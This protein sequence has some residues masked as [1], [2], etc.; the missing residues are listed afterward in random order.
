LL[1]AG[2]G[3]AWCAGEGDGLK[4]LEPKVFLPDGREFKT[5]KPTLTFSRT[6]YVDGSAANAS[7]DNPGTKVRPFKTINKAAQVAGAGQ[8]VLVAAGVYR[9]WVRPKRG[10]ESPAKMISYQAAPGA[11]VVIKGSRVVTDKWLAS[12]AKGVWKLTLQAKWFKNG[13]NPFALPNVTPKQFD[14]MSW[15]QRWR[16]KKPYTLPRGLVF[17]DA[18]RLVQV[19]TLDDLTKR[20][21]TYWVNVK[22]QILHIHPFDNKDPNT[23]V[24][25]ITTQRC[26]FAP[27]Q[28]GLGY[29]HVAGF[30]I[31]HAGN[32]FPFPQYGA[33]STW[34]GHHWLIERN[35]V[36]A[37]NSVGIDI[38]DQYWA[39]DQ[40]KIRSGRH[41]VRN[42]IITDCG[43]CGI[44][45]LSCRDSL[46]EN[47]LLVGNALYDVEG[48][49]ETAGIKTHGN[50]N[51]LIR[52]NRIFDTLHG[53][54]I[55][56]DFANVNS[57]CSRNIIVNSSTIHGG[58]FIEASLKP[59]MIDRNFIWNTRGAGIYEHDSRDQ[60]I[61][62]NF[63]GKSTGPAI[64]LR[65]KVTNRKVGGEKI[66]SGNHTVTNNILV[67]SKV[68]IETRDKHADLSNNVSERIVAKFDRK[69]MIL[70]WS[71]GAKSPECRA[72][73]FVIH[74]FF[75]KPLDPKTIA[76]GPF[77]AMPKS[78][79]KVKLHND[80][81]PKK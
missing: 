7:D 24:M 50:V 20:A 74:D 37:V 73:R 53:G 51:T 57:R 35:T 8:R 47:N 54:G 9:E 59:N 16:G 6:W 18:R 23:A 65:G 71:A 56:M 62:H 31:E 38:G 2:L 10:G 77:G 34:R 1:F 60:I 4:S 78:S 26:V 55:W 11:K 40:P 42:N 39:F 45:G 67:N 79:T 63:I 25:E 32:P 70:T 22:G 52:G 36:R 72:V 76:P 19:N 21:G 12:G 49:Y 28:T 61:C 43:V 27:E 48:Y 15:A 81:P 33:L 14:M 68:P 29:I 17:Q 80:A 66:V 30:I 44:Q 75:A 69:T 41:I 3:T 46:I 13:Y 5:W 58:I 64:R